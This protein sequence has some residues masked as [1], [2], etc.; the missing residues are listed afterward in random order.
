MTRGKFLI[1]LQSRLKDC[2]MSDFEI[3]ETIEDYNLIIDSYMLENIEEE[4]AVKMLGSLDVIVEGLISRRKYIKKPSLYVL[5]VT[6]FFTLMLILSNVF[7]G[8]YDEASANTRPDNQFRVVAQLFL[9]LGVVLIPIITY[10]LV[11]IYS[12]KNK[13]L[14]FVNK[15]I[16]VDNKEISNYLLFKIYRLFSIAAVI[17]VLVSTFISVIMD[18]NIESQINHIAPVMIVYLILCT[19]IL[20][21]IA[22][23]KYVGGEIKREFFVKGEYYSLKRVRAIIDLS[24][25]I[26]LIISILFSYLYIALVATVIVSINNLFTFLIEKIARRTNDGVIYMATTNYISKYNFFNRKANSIIIVFTISFAFTLL[27]SSTNKSATNLVNDTY[28]FKSEIIFDQMHTK[29]EIEEIF[30]DDEYYLY[31]RLDGTYV[32]TSSENTELL[33]IMFIDTDYLQDVCSIDGECQEVELSNKEVIVHKNY[34]EKNNLE[35]GD[36]I[37]LTISDVTSIYEIKYMT[38]DIEFY[39]EL[40]VMDNVIQ[41]LIGYNYMKFV[42]EGDY[43]DKLSDYDGSYVYRDFD[44]I[45]INRVQILFKHTEVIEIPL[46][47]LSL[48]TISYLFLDISNYLKSQELSHNNLKRAGIKESKIAISVMLEFILLMVVALVKLLLLTYIIAIIVDIL[49]FQVSFGVYLNFKFSF[50]TYFTIATIVL[51][52][53]MTFVLINFKRKRG[54]SYE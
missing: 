11:T 34:A 9:A 17:S 49:L 42:D 53:S 1:S 14:I 32:N 7:T 5:V 6:F 52:L 36:T 21:F 54:L 30:E 38:T 26:V 33:Y 27:V 41:D 47:L 31:T 45:E 35:I 16:G 50:G 24:L 44:D 51:L 23:K 13:D 22:V 48:I 8:L 20:G 15:R 18:S 12:D 46:I 40:L 29:T 3:A 25:I 19:L 4:E 39:F 10:R 43:T 28:H 2:G 37:E